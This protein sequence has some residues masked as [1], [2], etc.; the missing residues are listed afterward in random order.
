MVDE[1]AD[2]RAHLDNLYRLGEAV[3]HR[4][5]DGDPPRLCIKREEMWAG[6]N[7]G[8]TS[9]LAGPVRRVKG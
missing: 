8:I 1:I 2:G 9:T 6:W 5:D 7:P 3:D 4:A